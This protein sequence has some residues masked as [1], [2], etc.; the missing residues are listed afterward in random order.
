MNA[1]GRH[2]RFFLSI[3][4]AFVILVLLGSSFGAG[5]VVGAGPEAGASP[6]AAIAPSPH[7]ASASLAAAAPSAPLQPASNATGNG[8]F[9]T[10]HGLPTAPLVDQACAAGLCYNDSN[11]VSA[12]V[13]SGGVIV[14]AYTTLTDKSPCASMRPYSVANIAFTTSADHGSTW[15]TPRYLGNPVCTGVSAGYSDAWEPTIASLSNGTLVLAYVEFNLT[16]GALPPL[17]ST[18]WPPV[19]SRLVLTES[20]DG[21]AVW[22]TPAVLNVSNPPGAPPGLQYTPA[23]PSLATSGNT[24]Y[25]TWM[26]LSTENAIGAIALIVSSTG[27]RT[28]SPTVPVSEG[29]GA[30]YSMDPQVAV[31]PEGRVYIAYTSNISEESFLCGNFGCTFFENPVWLGSV[32]VA[33]SYTNGTVFNYTMVASQIPLGTPAWDPV[34]NPV[35]FGPFEL[36]AP[37]IAYDPT[38]DELFVAFVGGEVANNTQTCFESADECLVD[39]VYFYSSSD[40]DSSWQSGNIGTTLLNPD[41][42]DPSTV[43]QNSTDSVTSVALA[44]A[45]GTVYLEAGLYNGTVCFGVSPCGVETEVVVSSNDNGTTFTTPDILDAD[46]TPYADA[47]N[48]EYGSVVILHGAPAYLWSSD[49]CPAWATTACGPYPSSSLAVSQVEISTLFTGVGVTVSFTETGVPADVAWA[50]SVLGNY[51]T[52]AGGVTLAVSGVPTGYLTPWS[53]PGVYLPQ[54]RYLPAPGG[55]APASPQLLTK[56]LTVSVAFQEFVAVIITVNVPNIQGPEC[57]P[58]VFGIGGCPA[59]YPS[60]LGT[61]SYPFN[62]GNEDPGC[63][64]VFFNPQPPTGV[65]WQLVGQSESYYLINTPAWPCNYPYAGFFGYTFCTETNYTLSMLSWAGTGAGSVSTTSPNITFAPLGPVTETATM[66]ITGACATEFENFSGTFYFDGTYCY[67]YGEPL[68]IQEQGLPSGTEWGVTLGGASGSGDFSGSAGSPIVNPTAGVG[69]GTI[70]P[71]SLPSTVGGKVWVGT[72]VQGSSIIL[73]VS[74]PITVNYTLEPFAD[75]SVP[76]SVS[77]LGLPTGIEGNGTLTNTETGATTNVTFSHSATVVTVPAGDYLFSVPDVVTTGSVRYAPAEVY[78]VVALVNATNQSGLAPTA[79]ELDGPATLTAA[80]VP[81]YWLSVSAGPWGSVT[82]TSRWVSAGQGVELT[83]TP[84]AGYVFLR[85][86]GSGPGATSGDQAT[87]AD[88]VITPD[89][90]VTEVATFELTPTPTWTVTVNESGLPVGQSYTVTLGSQSYSGTGVF[91]ITNLSSGSYALGFPD[92]LGSGSTIVR[93]VLASVTASAGLGAGSLD[94]TAS[95]TLSPVYLPQFYVSIA[96]LGS[97]T[98]SSSPGGPWQPGSALFSSTATPAVGNVFVGWLGSVNGSSSVLITTSPT[99]S[100]TLN[101]SLDLIAQFAPAA[102]VIP[103]SYSLTIVQQTL[104]AGTTWQVALSPGHGA[105]GVGPSIVLTGLNGTYTLAFPT[106]FTSPGVR[107]VASFSG[108]SSQTI[109]AN[110]TLNVT[111]T[112]EF[113]VTLAVAGNAA[114]TNESWATAGASMSLQAPVSP[115][116]G[117]QFQGWQGNGPGSYSGPNATQSFVVSGP[118]TETA[119]YGPA[120]TSS[121]T[122]PVPVSDWVIFAVIVGVLAIV[123][124][125]EGLVA[126][127]RRRPRQPQLTPASNVP[128]TSVAGPIGPSSPP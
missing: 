101:G 41:D 30:F 69:V 2:G 28:W 14:A 34:V 7:G 19:E 13:T 42:I 88:V 83:A 87:T 18:S 17:T 15:S 126:G 24:I 52:G 90:P 94:V 118:V 22:S 54:I 48:G 53:V 103:P 85:W 125:A 49:G 8:T 97:G 70:T 105:A 102:K 127:R 40:N 60:C 23:L 57:S 82:P 116:V 86:D 6:A 108:G 35:S 74:N 68:S 46:Y 10:S 95:L 16:A 106:V 76:V 56:N 115:T 31:D 79:L 59:F 32:W 4:L 110:A 55:I 37:Q 117:W 77:A 80:Y 121:G 62:P 25:L 122:A 47:W 20:Y 33:S 120:T 50:V 65:Q 75:V 26:S 89:G 112:E 11:D 92:V 81:Q 124:I 38:T 12:L 43:A 64:S 36:P 96:V 61:A 29:T 113:L 39:N 1:R 44:V 21:G 9:Y 93:Y 107:Y 98:V 67:S 84:D 72:V 45:D 91:P 119:T 128:E 109:S 5:I 51:R 111:Y 104:P 78:A 63:F 27:G 66:I 58:D 123:G 3:A 71:W 99:L 100:V 114:V 73:P